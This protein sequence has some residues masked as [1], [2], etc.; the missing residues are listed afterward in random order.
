MNTPQLYAP[1][2]LRGQKD[3]Q[4]HFI[5]KMIEEQI[6]TIQKVRIERDTAS[7]E[8]VKLKLALQ[9]AEGVLL[10][11]TRQHDANAYIAVDKAAN[12]IDSALKELSE[13]T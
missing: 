8:V 7:A 2:Y 6:F 13:G 10:E 9:Q 3:P 5:A 12:I 11:F 1:D 4:L